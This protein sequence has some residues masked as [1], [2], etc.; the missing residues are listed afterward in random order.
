MTLPSEYGSPRDRRACTFASDGSSQNPMDGPSQEEGAPSN[1]F[2]IGLRVDAGCGTDDLMAGE[3]DL[4]R[5]IVAGSDDEA[6][7]VAAHVF[8]LPRSRV[9]IVG[10]SNHPLGACTEKLM[11]VG[12]GNQERV[13]SSSS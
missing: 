4:C 6:H 12:R 7:S 8:P 10:Y 2:D 1:A 13:C 5:L 3:V 11:P 9:L